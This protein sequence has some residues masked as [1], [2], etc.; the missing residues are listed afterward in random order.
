[1]SNA[2]LTSRANFNAVGP[3]QI[4][5]KEIPKRLLDKPGTSP[6]YG[7][8]ALPAAVFA[9]RKQ[10]DIETTKQNFLMYESNS[11]YNKYADSI[12]PALTRN[13]TVA[14][15]TYTDHHK[16]DL[17]EFDPKF[18]VRNLP[19]QKP[20][21]GRANLYPVLIKNELIHGYEW[22]ADIL[23]TAWLRSDSGDLKQTRKNFLNEMGLYKIIVLPFDTFKEFGANLET[24][25]YFCKKDY[26]GPI[27]IQ[28]YNSKDSYKYDF[29][30][31]DVIVTPRSLEEV[32]FIFDCVSKPHYEIKGVGSSFK[33]IKKTLKNAETATFKY[34]VIDK[35]KKT[36]NNCT[37]KYTNKIYDTDIDK[38]R[39]V[40]SYLSAGWGKGDKHVGNLVYVPPGYQ[41]SGTYKYIVVKNKK[42]ANATIVYLNSK[43]ARYLLHFWRTSRTCDQP[44]WN[45][46]PVLDRFD[47][48]TEDNIL[49]HFVSN[50][51]LKE[52][53]RNDR[54]HEKAKNSEAA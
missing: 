29:R 12:M 22:T 28:H 45:S 8:I 38:H 23:P 30:K 33:E 11:V 6:Y 39:V 3:Y 50:D 10:L 4:M 17:K 54:L 7:S 16:V 48:A 24:A 32:D 15:V 1:M 34:P 53:I 40:T 13:T 18:S 31:T 46:I 43:F 14:T 51:S 36:L 26:K 2:S 21:Q 42:E 35:L 44:Q 37:F 20:G 5:A 9:R 49:D 41:L 19:Y 27:E 52:K 47:L 25:I